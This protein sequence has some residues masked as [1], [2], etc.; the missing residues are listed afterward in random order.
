MS[1]RPSRMARYIN[2]SNQTTLE[3]ITDGPFPGSR[4]GPCNDAG[5]LRPD[6]DGP[7]S[8]LRRARAKSRPGLEHVPV[9][10]RQSLR[11]HSGA[12]HRSRVYPRSAFRLPKSAIADL[13]GASPESITT[14]CEYGFR[15]R[16]TQ[17]SLRRLRKLACVGAPE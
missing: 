14:A 12:R 6:A 7:N 2:R 8:I 10:L 3:G 5:R 11:R 16:R 13:G 4:H 1:T 15:A 17:P 9:G